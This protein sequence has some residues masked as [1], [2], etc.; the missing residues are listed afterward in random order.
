[1]FMLLLLL[2]FLFLLRLDA[3]TLLQFAK[4]KR[5]GHEGLVCCLLLLLDGEKRIFA[6]FRRSVAHRVGILGSD[7]V[8]MGSTD[9]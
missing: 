6:D 9:L 3:V 8:L 2:V 7:K 5:V 4:T 1:M